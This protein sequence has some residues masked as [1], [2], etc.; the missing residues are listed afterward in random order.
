MLTAGYAKVTHPYIVFGGHHS[1]H[2][3]FVQSKF[4]LNMRPK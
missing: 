4:A 1:I 2:Y 3:T